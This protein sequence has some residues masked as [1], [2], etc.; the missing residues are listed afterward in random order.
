MNIGVT[1]LIT[2]EYNE[3]LLIQRNDTRTWAA[4]GGSLEMG[5]LPIDGAIREVEEETGLKTVP[6]RLTNINYRTFLGR[7]SLQFVFRCLQSGG[8][9]T[10][11]EE[12][13]AVGYFKR[14]QLPPILRLSRQAIEEG[15]YHA[16]PPSWQ[17]VPV[18]WRMLPRWLWLKW[19][20]YPRLDRERKRNGTAQ[21]QPPPTWQVTV[22]VSVQNQNGERLWVE[23]GDGVRQLLTSSRSEDLPPWHIAESLVKE[24]LGARVTMQ[25]LAGVFVQRDTAHMVLLW[26]SEPVTI[27]SPDF[28][29]DRPTHHS[30]THAHWISFVEGSGDAV[31][32]EHF[33]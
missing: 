22:A 10:E 32:Y 30:E 29:A 31:A 25:R 14:K 24:R 20:V 17:Q 4:P 28:F 21:Y 23:N 3:I 1:G 12:S 15:W 11:S 13:L 2:N 6:V 16:G 5:E 8:Q 26:E 19:V 27:D 9:I 7:A 18:P 33:D